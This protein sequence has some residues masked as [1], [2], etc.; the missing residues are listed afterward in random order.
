MKTFEYVT[1]LF[2]I[3]LGVCITQMALNVVYVI[4]NFKIAVLYAPA[5]LWNAAALVA[6]LAH[7]VHFYKAA[8]RENWDALQLTI[9]FI[10]PLI[11]FI[12][13]TLLAQAPMIE[14][15]LNYEV[16]FEANKTLI[17]STVFLFACFTMAQHYFLYN[18]R[19][20]FTYAYYTLAM[21]MVSIA[22][23]VDSKH[24]DLGLSI[25]IFISEILN[26]YVIN[27]MTLSKQ[28]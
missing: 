24:L 11:Y 26:H 5:I 10:T 19:K 25:V 17:Y 22:L 16:L 21:V 4:Q 9:V 1:I 6:I 23:L 12:P 15:R 13:A 20:I 2:S 8:N 27:P 14:G 28:L 3:L 18:N 7:W